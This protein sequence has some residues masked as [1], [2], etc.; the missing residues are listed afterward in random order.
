MPTQYLELGPVLSD[1]EHNEPLSPDVFHKY[2]VDI[3]QGL[4]YLQFQGIV[5]R[6]GPP[7]LWM[8]RQRGCTASATCL[9]L[10]ATC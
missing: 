9:H 2:F 7:P 6:Y 5:H 8:H 1:S 3:V 10:F 4:E